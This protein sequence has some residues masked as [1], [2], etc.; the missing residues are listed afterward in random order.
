MTPSQCRA[1]RGLLNWNQVDLARTARVSVVTVRNFENEKSAPL[2]ATLDVIQRALETAG[3]EF[4]DGDGVRRAKRR[5]PKAARKVAATKTA[6]S[7][8]RGES[9]SVPVRRVESPPLVAG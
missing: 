7:R 9:F 8:S 6:K 3:V 2:R 4:I 5:P 1:A